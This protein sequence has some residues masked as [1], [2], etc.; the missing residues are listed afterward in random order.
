VIYYHHKG[1]SMGRR[2]TPGTVLVSV[3]LDEKLVAEMRAVVADRG[4]TTRRVIERAL[5]RHLDNL[6][7]VVIPDPPLPPIPPPPA[8]KPRKGK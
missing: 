3:E 5:R 6:P 2:T 1:V 8:P 7:P 4:E